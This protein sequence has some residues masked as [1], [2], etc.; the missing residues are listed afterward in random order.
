LT[1]P[2][3]THIK[4]KNKPKNKKRPRG[5][6]RKAYKPISEIAKELEARAT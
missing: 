3:H 5:W 1:M 6:H 2:R 4:T